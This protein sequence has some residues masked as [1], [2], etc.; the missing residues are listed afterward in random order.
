[1]SLQNNRTGIHDRI[2][3]VTKHHYAMDDG[4]LGWYWLCWPSVQAWTCLIAP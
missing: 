1:M 3:N 4:G 2:V